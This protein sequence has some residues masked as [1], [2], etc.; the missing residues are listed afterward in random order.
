MIAA[1]NAWAV[2]SATMP[3]GRIRTLTEF[4]NGR[5]WQLVPSPTPGAYAYL[6]GVTASWTHNI[7]AVGS[8]DPTYCIG[9]GCEPTLTLV[10]HWNGARWKIVPSPNGPTPDDNGLA[11]IAAVSRDDIWAAGWS[12]FETLLTHWNGSAWS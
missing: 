12:T 10:L 8:T 9:D 7:W 5:H 2:G 11:G 6:L 4:W 1:D 3:G